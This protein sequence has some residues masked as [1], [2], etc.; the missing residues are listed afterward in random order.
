M[1][2][3]IERDFIMMDISTIRHNMTNSTEKPTVLIVDDTPDNITILSK[4]LSEYNIKAAN[5]GVK[6]IEIAS[7]FNPDIILLDVMMPEMDGYFRL[8]MN[9]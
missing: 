5:N 6:A 8:M 7:R 1:R 4:V 2:Q 9:Q 3:F